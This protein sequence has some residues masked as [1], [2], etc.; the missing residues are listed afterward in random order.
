MNQR[1]IKHGNVGFR[2]E[3]AGKTENNL[4]IILDFKDFNI[5]RISV[6]IIC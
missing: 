4:A 2:Y 1:L 6:S 5:F 3:F